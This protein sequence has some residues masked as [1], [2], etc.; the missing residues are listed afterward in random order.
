MER[1]R[2]IVAEQ[3][4]VSTD[5]IGATTSL[6]DLAADELDCVE[7]IMQL[8]NAFSITIPDDTAEELTGGQDWQE[9][10]KNV[11]VQKLSALVDNR[12]N[13]SVRTQ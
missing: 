2:R 10:M 11:T 1:V 3:M 4:G 5:K 13:Q 12:R 8:E 9:G 7:L 6:D